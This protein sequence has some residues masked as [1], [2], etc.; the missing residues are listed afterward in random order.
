MQKLPQ[1]KKKKLSHI[2]KDIKKISVNSYQKNP[3]GVQEIIIVVI[4]KL[5]FPKSTCNLPKEQYPDL[6]LNQTIIKILQ[7]ARC[8]KGN[9]GGYGLMWSTKIPPFQIF[10]QAVS[11]MERPAKSTKIQPLCPRQKC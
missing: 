1:A 4:L 10:M 2:K 6:N 9:A 3:T 5:L 11:F 7:V 8:S